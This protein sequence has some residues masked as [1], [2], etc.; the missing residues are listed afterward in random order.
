MAI[1]LLD[2]A[3]LEAGNHRIRPY[4]DIWRTSVVATATIDT[5]KPVKYPTFKLKLADAVGFDDV[6]VGMRVIIRDDE[7]R[8]VATGVVRLPPDDDAGVIT[9]YIDAKSQGDGGYA[10]HLAIPILAGQSV[11]IYNDYP[12]WGLLSRIVDGRF[13]KLYD[14]EYTDEGDNPPP[15]VNI[16]KWRHAFVND[17]DSLASFTF[18]TT[19]SFAWYGKTIAAT[20]WTLPEE[21]VVTGGATNGATVT[22]TLPVGFYLIECT[23]GDSGG[24]TT[25]AVRPVWV[26]VRPGN[27]QYRDLMPLSHRGRS[28]FGGDRQE[29]SGRNKELSLFAEADLIADL[30]Y[31]G[32]AWVYWEESFFDEQTVTTGV[33]IEEF[34]GFATSEE[35]VGNSSRA[36][37]SVDIASPYQILSDIPMVNQ[38]IIEKNN[39]N[40]WIHVKRPYSDQNLL[41]W[42]VLKWHCPNQLL[43]FD[44][45]RVLTPR[46]KRRYAL[47]GATI[48][49]QCEEIVGLIAGA[50]GSTSDGETMILRD[51][52]I[53]GVAFRD[54]L[55]E[56]FVIEDRHIVG[57]VVFPQQYRNRV[58]QY[59]G[60]AFYMDNNDEPAPC[61]AVAPGSAQGQ[62]QG[63][64]QTSS[65]LV[66]NQGELNDM[67]GNLLARENDP[68]GEFQLTMRMNMDIF[69]PMRHFNT[70]WKIN[71][72]ASKNPRGVPLEFRAMVRS[73]DR[74]YREAASG[75]G[76][77]VKTVVP[78]FVRETYGEPGETMEVNTGS[79]GDGGGGNGGGDDGGGGGGSTPVYLGIAWTINGGFARSRNFNKSGVLWEN[80]KGDIEGVI[81]HA[82]FDPY[83]NFILNNFD[84]GK[85][86][87]FAIATDGTALQ[88][89][90]CKSML[91]SPPEW[92]LADT[93]TM[94]DATCV[95][96]ARIACSKT[97]EGLVVYAWRDRTGTYVN[98]SEDRGETWGDVVRVGSGAGTDTEHDDFPFGLA[99]DGSTVICTDRV[100]GVYRL[101]YSP[102]V[103]EAFVSV[104]G[105]PTGTQPLTPIVFDDSGVVY[106]GEYTS[107]YAPGQDY[108]DTVEAPPTD[109]I[110]TSATG[111]PHYRIG[112]LG[113][114]G[115]EG[116]VEVADPDGDYTV[117]VAATVTFENLVDLEYATCTSGYS[118]NF[119][120]NPYNINVGISVRGE[121]PTNQLEFVGVQYLATG[122]FVDPVMDD[123]I[124]GVRSVRFTAGYVTPYD[125][126]GAATFARIL[127]DSLH[128]RTAR[129]YDITREL[130][131]VTDYN[132]GAAL[133]TVITPE[134]HIPAY[135]EA[136]AI[137]PINPGL[138]TA[139]ADKE[140]DRRVYESP[141]YG[142]AWSNI[143]A[144]TANHRGVFRRGDQ[145]IRWGSTA[146]DYQDGGLEATP[147][148]RV[149][150]WTSSVGS[151]GEFL[152]VL[153]FL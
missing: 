135:P 8:E 1:T 151:I 118:Y 25:R 61:A 139:L 143:S 54:L 110:S 95:S 85:L 91:A 20:A 59:I 46:R 26:H 113:S 133:W 134:D 55:E 19:G 98:W 77:W 13:V 65:L 11:S 152:G 7:E 144:N 101:R 49:Q 12:L 79:G 69:D 9:L 147:V 34:V 67:V 50:I 81:N 121:D 94:A 117:V 103:G 109:G 132:N 43:L 122:S 60:Y 115:Y 64:S 74:Q 4:Y 92:V 96:S 29:I 129:E 63:K 149:G 128:L 127:L 84:S 16:G 75:S 119:E 31:P 141:D 140:D 142:Q 62:A 112:D 42:Y 111:S 108:Y 99:I 36:L 88:F 78:T 137:D 116:Y 45:K 104:V 37:L 131:G 6:K 23:L 39:P 124:A 97:V 68:T 58:G 80:I 71:I 3:K 148:S 35:V 150:D 66:A 40:K 93:Q 146:I 10:R 105:D 86:R 126:G 15:V 53:E 48:A 130:Y 76:V 5:D 24:A 72:S 44:F 57:E 90:Y 70:W 52:C 27:P 14:V 17:G 56:R 123:E 102:G 120:D 73:V 41:V 100:D 2:Q 38:A 136:L 83:S 51:P 33:M 114:L 125:K 18:V 22:F 153:T 89:W 106:V 28:R 107:E 21:A 32:A 87:G 47:N 138:V 30:V 82:Q 145:L